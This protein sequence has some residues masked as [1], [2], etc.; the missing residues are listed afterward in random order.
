MTIRE[1]IYAAEIILAEARLCQRNNPLFEK[2][3]DMV[4]FKPSDF[5]KLQNDLQHH[6][7]ME[8]DK[9]IQKGISLDL[10]K[11]IMPRLLLLC[12]AMN[13]SNQYLHT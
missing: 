9:S 10:D 2:N 1:K 4:G 6:L 8:D 5:D 11:Y 3:M 13:K 7:N 12:E